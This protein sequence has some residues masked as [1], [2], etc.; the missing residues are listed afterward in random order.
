MEAKFRNSSAP[1]LQVVTISFVIATTLISCFVG[2]Y[3]LNKRIGSFQNAGLARAVE[4][5]AA[6]AQLALGQ[7]LY[8]EWIR[9][10]SAAQQASLLT[11]LEFQQRL[12][13]MTSGGSVSWAGYARNDGTVLAASNGVLVNADVSSRPWFKQGLEGNFAGDVHEAVLLASKL[14]RPESGEPLRFLDMAVPVAGTGDSVDGVL[15]IHLDFAWARGIVQQ[16]AEALQVDLFIVNSAGETVMSTADGDFG[17]LDLASYRA[18]RTG[19]SSVH[20]ETWPDGRSYFTATVPERGIK[21]LPRFGWSVIARIDASTALGG[22]KTFAAQLMQSLLAYAVFIILVTSL[23]IA[24]F[25]RPFSRLARNAVSVAEG[26][27]T[28][29][30]ESRRTRELAMMSAALARL[31][32]HRQKGES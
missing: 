14:P 17:A 4:T 3:V 24:I 7:A 25:I 31:Q 5:R 21:D 2:Y 12:N 20:V 28:Y 27:D 1:S 10:R 18:A 15:G 32:S 11:P 30:F 23:F 26:H 29:P 9:L 19:A 8:G 6:G 16:M 13:T 22:S